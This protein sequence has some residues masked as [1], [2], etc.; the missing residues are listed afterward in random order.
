MLDSIL[1]KIAYYNGI[2]NGIV[3]GVPM[4][5]LIIGVGIF[6]TIRTK[7]F[8]LT[9]AK[10]VYYNTIKGIINSAKDKKNAKYTKNISKSKNRVRKIFRHRQRYCPLFATCNAS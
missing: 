5:C 3:W 4:L 2:A 7:C 9:H 6:Y 1:G 10:D 8:Q